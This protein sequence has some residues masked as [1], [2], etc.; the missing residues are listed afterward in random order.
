MQYLVKVQKLFPFALHQLC[1]GDACPAPYDL[2]D[3]LIG[4][5]VSEQAVLL[6]LLRN[7]IHLVKLLFKGGYAA[8]LELCRLVVVALPLCGGKL[9]LGSLYILTQLL[10]TADGVLLVLPAGLH[11]VELIPQLGELLLYLCQPL[12]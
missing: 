2:C 10:H 7:V 12:L 8:V 11:L 6:C 3:F 5:T 1:N 9:R 4:D